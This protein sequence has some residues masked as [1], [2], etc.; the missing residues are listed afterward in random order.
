MAWGWF[1]YILFWVMSLQHHARL[2]VQ[3]NLPTVYTRCTTNPNYVCPNSTDTPGTVT[4]ESNTILCDP[5]WHTSQ[6]RHVTEREKRDVC[7]RYNQLVGCPGKGYEIDHLVSLEIGG[8]NDEMN[9]W[10][11]PID[12]ARVKD[13]VEN[14]LHRKVCSGAMTLQEAQQGIAKDWTQYV[15]RY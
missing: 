7:A 4:S 12:Q 1:A 6:E 10:P 8:S 5:S 13:I 15:N 9:L 2:Q 3:A 14:E 11:Q